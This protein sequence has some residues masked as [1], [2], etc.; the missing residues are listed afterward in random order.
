MR[1]PFL[2]ICITAVALSLGA[3]PPSEGEGD[4]GTGSA[5]ESTSESD[6]ETTSATTG[7][8]SSGS[9]S[10]SDP[11]MGGPRCGD[12]ILDGGETCDDGNIS[13]ADSC[14]ADCTPASC[15][16]GFVWI[17]R[18]ECDD[19]EENDATDAKR[20]RLN[21]SRP[22]CG[23]GAL[24]AL[25]FGDAIGLG[26]S[27]QFTDLKLSEKSPRSIAIDGAGDIYTVFWSITVNINRV[28]VE[29]Y[30]AD[31]TLKSS[32]TAT[33]DQDPLYHP[34]LGVSADGTITVAWQ[35]NVANVIYN[36]F[37]ARFTAEGET[38]IEPSSISVS[39]TSYH[40]NP[41]VAVNPSGEAIVAFR[42]Q[43]GMAKL[44]EI[45]ARLLPAEGVAPD[46]FVVSAFAGT[47]APS[48]AIRSDGSFV[49]AYSERQMPGKI[50]VHDYSS[51]GEQQFVIDGIAGLQGDPDNVNDIF[52][53]VGAAALENGDF[54]VA[55]ANPDGQLTIKRFNSE[56]E[57]IVDVIASPMAY[58]W[59]PQIDLHSDAQG[60]LVALWAGC[61][62]K[63]EQDI[64]CQNLTQLYLQ[65]IYADG[66]LFG[67][68]LLVDPL[69]NWQRRGIGVAVGTSSNVAVSAQNLGEPF[70][71]IAK[72]EC[73]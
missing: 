73:L 1:R 63:G 67:D 28:T 9:A 59:I 69:D 50:S 70:L 13:N 20:C 65:Q 54:A 57:L 53:W 56:G 42:T 24:Y 18:E 32:F 6:T 62:L 19:G 22:R 34:S 49:I 12:G 51:K 23:D 52:P 21:C 37:Y 36:V 58:A 47:S 4:A 44:H 30:S 64:A 25:S 26:K 3:C 27:E 46:P 29:R 5:S 61:G 39:P 60:N 15:G 11:T 17:G 43:V 48:V 10:S 33:Q 72:A 2:S 16:D 38:L 45:R 41:V 66:T 8:T 35:R 31:G 40:R 7:E 55:G 14:L 68:A 71:K